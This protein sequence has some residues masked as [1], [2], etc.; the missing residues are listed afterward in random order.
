MDVLKK[1]SIAFKGLGEGTHR[2]DMKV[3]DRFFEAFEGSEIRRGN[4]DVRLTLDKRGNGMA[5]DFD[6]RGEV[7]V[8]CDRCL[9]EFMM[10]VRYEGTLHV[11]YSDCERESDG[12][13][14]WISPSETELNVAQYIYE[15]ICLSL[16]YQRVHPDDSEGRSTWRSRHA[17]ALP[18]RQR[19]RVRPP[20]SGDRNGRKF[21]VGK[22]QGN[23]ALEIASSRTGS[24]GRQITKNINSTTFS[25]MAHP[26]HKVSSTRRDKRRTHYKAEVP[27][28][29]T[30]S[31]CGAA[32]LYHRV[33]PECGFYR[34]RLAIEKKAE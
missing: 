11:R 31:N 25:K 14:M 30:C 32:V 13:V 16:P 9:E 17:V 26:K 24:Q 29:S 5:L 23:Q 8:E 20:V 21:S 12:E 15:S 7:A 4:A 3:D 33:C 22:T 10:P 2:F 28:V 6:I 27:T 34:G 18:D 1:Y 19:G